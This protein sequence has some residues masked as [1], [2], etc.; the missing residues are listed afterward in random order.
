MKLKLAELF[1]IGSVVLFVQDL[2]VHGWLF[3]AFSLLSRFFG[4]AWANYE[5]EQAAR[6]L[7][8]S[9]ENLGENAGDLVNQ[10]LIFLN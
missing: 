4:V 6:K 2:Q 9:I 8:Q 10:M 7:E 5:K 1:L 3:F